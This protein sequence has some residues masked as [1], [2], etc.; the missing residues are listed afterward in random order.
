MKKTFV[1][2]FIALSAFAAVVANMALDRV[3]LPRFY[4]FHFGRVPGSFVSFT[5]AAMGFRLALPAGLAPGQSLEP[6]LT[7]FSGDGLIV[8]VYRQDNVPFYTYIGYGNRP[9][10]QG[11][12]DVNVLKHRRSWANLRAVTELW[13]QRPAL[14]R[15]QYDLPYYASVDIVTG[16]RTTYTLLFRAA[17]RQLLSETVPAVV[18]SFRPTAVQAAKQ[19]PMGAATEAQRA[20]PMHASTRAYIASLLSSAPPRWG[21]FEPTYPTYP[22][23]LAQIEEVVDHRFALVLL[24]N[25]LDSVLPLPKL[26]AL[27]EDGR[28]ALLTLQTTSRAGRPLTYDI[29]S[30]RYDDFLRSYARDVARFGHPVLFRLNNEMNGDWCT[31]S[32]YHSSKDP[33]LFIELWRY[34]YYIFADEGATNAAW[35]WNPHDLSFPNFAWNQPLAYF[36]GSAYVDIV[37]LTGYNTGTY[38]PAETWRSF[39]EIYD[40]LYAEYDE[41]YPG[42]PFIVTEFASATSGGDRIAWLEAM[43]QDLA[44]YP[45]ISAYIWWNHIDYDGEIPARIYRLEPDDPGWQV[46]KRMFSY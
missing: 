28:T 38:Y 42:Y 11:S 31:Y 46:F 1:A 20:T 18:S 7:R 25:S 41:M 35:V 17:S 30:G 16:L 37:G 24:Y 13:W 45:R 36:P 12:D 19:Q 10:V 6:L 44:R 15:L 21:I 2:L 9:I 23:L 32:A 14:A 29:L 33:L 5:S 27:H 22:Y 8:D 26:N 4:S 3:G 34:I 43:S 40:P 39:R